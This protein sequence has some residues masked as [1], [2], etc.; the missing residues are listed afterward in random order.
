MC[1]RVK[2]IGV[3]KEFAPFTAPYIKDDD[4]LTDMQRNLLAMIDRYRKNESLIPEKDKRGKYKKA[5][6]NLRYDILNQFDRVWNEA[7]ISPRNATH[8]SIVKK[9]GNGVTSLDKIVSSAYTVLTMELITI[10]SDEFYIHFMTEIKILNDYCADNTGYQEGLK[11]F[12]SFIAAAQKENSKKNKIRAVLDAVHDLENRS[13]EG[14][15]NPT[16]EQWSWVFDICGMV[17]DHIDAEPI[18]E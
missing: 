17:T 6:S 16:D 1:I 13:E 18:P 4:G 10:P 14:T 3:I 11:E 9:E 8:H 12:Q 5:L 2:N 15:Y 7:F